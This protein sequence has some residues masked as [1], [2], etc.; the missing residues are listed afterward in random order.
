MRTGGHLLAVD[1]LFKHKHSY[2]NTIKHT[3][4]YK[5]ERKWGAYNGGGLCVCPITIVSINLA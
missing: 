4:N 2:T 1:L 3:C 5:K